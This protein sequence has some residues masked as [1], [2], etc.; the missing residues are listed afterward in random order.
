MDYDGYINQ[1]QVMTKGYV[2]LLC[3]MKIAS[4]PLLD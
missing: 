3:G 2:G 4:C 1:I